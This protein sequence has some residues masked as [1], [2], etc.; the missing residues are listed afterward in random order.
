MTHVQLWIY[1]LASFQR[2]GVQ[3]CTED[4]QDLASFGID[5]S[6]PLPSHEYDGETCSDVSVEVPEIPCH[7]NDAAI[8]QLKFE[9][10]LIEES[11]CYGSFYKL[12]FFYMFHEKVCQYQLS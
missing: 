7:L 2:K 12:V 3:P 9:I 8:N 1:E 4:H 6:G 11:S 10:D 5:Y